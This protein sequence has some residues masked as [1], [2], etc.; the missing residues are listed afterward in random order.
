[1]IIL[2][3]YFGLAHV[4]WGR[5]M[6]S[7][8]CIAV[9]ESGLIKEFLKHNIACILTELVKVRVFEAVPPR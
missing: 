1:M 7:L 5:G 6:N 9:I 4:T 8:H 3:V 2:T